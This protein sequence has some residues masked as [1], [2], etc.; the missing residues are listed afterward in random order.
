MIESLTLTVGGILTLG[1]FSSLYRDNPLYRF[2]EHLLIGVSAGYFAS[3]FINQVVK[4]NLLA[5]LWPSWFGVGEQMLAEPNLWLLIP[6]ILGALMLFRTHPTLGWLSR[7]TV[8]FVVGVG[9]GITLV[10]AAH[11]YLLPQL[12]KAV[13]PLYISGDPL[14]S[15]SNVVLVVGTLSCLYFFLFGVERSGPV[16]KRV[17]GLGTFF[18]MVSFG[19]AFGATV[20]GRI[21]LLIGRVQFLLGDWLHLIR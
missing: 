5:R 11:Q 20:M 10:Y 21:S 6:A 12:R 4:P 7:V 9:A 8:G 14:Q 15:F 19:A 3:L 2:V 17:A 1:V 16:A 13:V 18:L